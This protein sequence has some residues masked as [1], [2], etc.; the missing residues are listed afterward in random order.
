MLRSLHDLENYAIRATDGDIGHVEDFFF[1]DQAWVIRYLV[2]ETGSWL[3][4]RKVLISPMAMGVPD[5]DQRQLPVAITR[6]Q[7]RNSP[8]IDTGQPVSRAHEMRYLGYYGYPCYWGGSGLW[9]KGRYPGLML[10][11]NGD[12]TAPPDGAGPLAGVAHARQEAA[13]HLDEDPHLRS[14]RAV[15]EYR[16]QARDGEIGHVQGVLVDEDTWAIDYLVANT[17]NW[18]LGHLVL[19]APQWIDS[20]RWLESTVCVNLSRH[21]IRSA[22]PYRAARPLNWIDEEEL[23]EHYGRNLSRPEELA[24]EASWAQP[25]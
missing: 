4:S 21:A 6:E 10:T 24:H 3:S 19:V 13:R 23:F 22:P 2:V 7:V 12:R 5:W 9:G 14:A 17:S 8:D 11:G 18:W 1:D 15:L 16:V 25:G 20:V